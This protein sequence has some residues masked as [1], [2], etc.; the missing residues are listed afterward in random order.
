MLQYSVHPPPLS[1][2]FSK[3]IPSST[4]KFRTNDRRPSTATSAQPPRRDDLR[5]LTP[6]FPPIQRLPPLPSHLVLPDEFDDL[7]SP[8]FPPASLPRPISRPVPSHVHQSSSPASYFHSPAP[9]SVSS[10]NADIP[11]IL[12]PGDIIGLDVPLRSEPLRLATLPA[13]SIDRPPAP[14]T[15]PAD[16]EFE[17]V[18]KL[19]TGSYA[20]V[21][22]VREI[23][24][25]PPSS[26]DGH[27]YASG[28][29]D[30]DGPRSP[31]AQY[32]RE[33]AV[34][35]LSK[36]NLDDDALAAQLFE[37]TVHQSLPSHPNLVSLHRTFET[38]SYLL[39]LL[40]FVPGE[41]LF[42]F[43]EQS[44]DHYQT[45]SPPSPADPT[46]PLRDSRTPPT[47]GLLSSQHPSQLL[48]PVRLRLIASMFAQ[49]CE[50]VAVCHDHGVFHRDIKPENFIVTDG[51]TPPDDA[52]RSERRVLV[53]LSDFGLST[54]DI[55]S[56]D[57]DC[58]SAPYMAYECRN[59]LAPTYRPRAADVWSLGIVLINML[60]H[61]NPWTDTA[62]GVCSSFSAYRAAPV[63]FLTQRFPGMSPAVA[64]FLAARVFCILPDPRSEAPRASAREL[65][66]WVRDLPVHFGANAG[67]SVSQR[68][69]SRGGSVS[70]LGHGLNSVPPSRR[71]ASRVG[72]TAG[73][74]MSRA[75]S[76]VGI[77]AEEERAPVI[78]EEAEMEEI[79]EE[80]RELVQD[81]ESRTSTS[82]KR[83]KRGARKGKGQAASPSPVPP[84]T[85]EILASASQTLARELSRASKGTGKA[86]SPVASVPPVPAIPATVAAAERAPAKKPSIWKL[87]FGSKASEGS[88]KDKEREQHAHRDEPPRGRAA[89]VSDLILGLNAPPLPS[90]KTSTGRAGGSRTRPRRRRRASRLARPRCPCRP[91]WRPRPARRRS[92]AQCVRAPASR[93]GADACPSTVMTGV[94]WELAELPRQLHPKPHGDIFGQPPAPRPRRAKQAAK[95][96]DHNNL[97]TI[98]ESR[99]DA[100][101]S[102]TD[103]ALSPG[104]EGAG[105]DGPK[106]VQRGQINA[107]AKMLGALR[108]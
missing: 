99:V 52:G 32:G 37:A 88:G 92:A 27:V 17:V 105:E 94:P 55:E 108:R 24:S 41:D 89:N 42:Y 28:K 26:D 39:L 15:P 107:L 30:L 19:G 16:A 36:A 102:T 68:G 82:T 76:V 77:V 23:L 48:S 106:K 69:H 18:R 14:D 104:E 8:S 70:S 75:P 56:S 38:P 13:P 1:V 65:G 47:P 22:L 4:L 50:A 2:S 61:C 45:S 97:G 3:K 20:V 6:Q 40:E 67:R 29:L 72:S 11:D 60:Y 53:K 93:L 12:V 103:L 5:P 34:K 71:P 84:D 51:L 80:P 83:R 96:P 57:M 31:P 25:R 95:S 21:Y 74:R 62:D 33:Y 43:L 90:S 66:A 85:S 54:K 73:V 101:T 46:D 9:S 10:V 79:V 35:L 59:N 64:S 44:R 98:S 86:S 78:S 58:G 87:G 81:P 100:G 63:V 7:P 49:M 91:V